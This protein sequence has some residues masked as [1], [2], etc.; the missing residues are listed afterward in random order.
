MPR[1]TAFV[2]SGS[3]MCDGRRETANVLQEHRRSG[4]FRDLYH[5]FQETAR[6][7]TTF[8]RNSRLHSTSYLINVPKER[9]SFRLRPHQ[10]CIFFCRDM[11]ELFNALCLFINVMLDISGVLTT[12]K[13]FPH[14]CG[15]GKTVINLDT[16]YQPNFKGCTCR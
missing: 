13:Y 14:A 12:F 7:N 5:C 3:G 4:R 15:V 11:C 2:F 6:A 1:H 16:I 10:V 8:T 9:F